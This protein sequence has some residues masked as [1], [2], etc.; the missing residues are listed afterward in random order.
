MARRANAPGPEVSVVVPTCARPTQLARCLLA[1][2]RQTLERTRYEV[3]V[4]DDAV[5]RTGPAA[6][7]NRG[8]RLANAP[9]IAFTDDDTE[10]DPDWL[11]AGLAAIAAGADAVSGAIVMPLTGVREVPSDYERDARGLERADF[12]TAN[13]FVRRF[14]LVALGG[15]DESFRLPWREDSDLHFRLL[16][17]GAKVVRAPDALV[18]HPVRPARFGV[19]LAQQRKIMFDALLYKKH[20]WLYR[21]RIRAAP[22]WDYYAVV[23]A[24]LA[25]VTALAAGAPWL[26]ALLFCIWI[27]LTARFS[28]HRLRGSSRRPIDVLE[29]I[30][31][32]IAIPPLA[33]FWRA[34]GALRFRSALT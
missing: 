5:K 25:A 21:Q 30:L 18:L 1:L 28:A 26:A 22:R 16:K 27:A 11:R 9:V 10:P 34:V 32:S 3:I 29:V 6:A 13:C 19:S 23:G 14:F 31:T 33:V 12:V 7:R 20:P 8:W 24:L 4:V 17:M 15:F 2:E